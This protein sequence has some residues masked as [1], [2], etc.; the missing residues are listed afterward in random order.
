MIKGYDLPLGLDVEISQLEEL[1]RK[2]KTG[3]VSVTE[4][5]AHRVPFGVYEQRQAG[6]YMVRIRCAGGFVTPQQLETVSA[7]AQEYGVSDLH[8]TSRQELQ[9]HYVKL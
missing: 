2:Y 6:T 1:I 9:I 4:L 8:I 7:I 3:E 5:K